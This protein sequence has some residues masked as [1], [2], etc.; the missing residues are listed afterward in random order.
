MGIQVSSK[1]AK[2]N[3]RYPSG[4]VPTES[5]ISFNIQVPHTYDTKEVC[6]VWIMMKILNI[7]ICVP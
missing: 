6:L 7:I 2:G 3:F 1:Y 4:A 5:T